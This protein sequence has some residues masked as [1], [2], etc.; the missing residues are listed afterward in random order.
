MARN[1]KNKIIIGL[2]SFF[3]IA[4]GSSIMAQGVPLATS[5]EL[6]GNLSSAVSDWINK[7]KVYLSGGQ[8]DAARE[9]FEEAI[10][11]NYKSSEA[12]F[13]LGLAEYERGDYPAALFE[14][15]EVARLYPEFFDGYYNRA[16]TL[17]KMRR[18]EEAAE[19]FQSAI[20]E[21]EPEAST[22]QKINAYLG[23]AGMLKK[24]ENYEAAADAYASALELREGDS[25]L[26]YRRGEAL[27]LAGNGLDALADLIELE[28]K[29]SDYRVSALI[30]DIYVQ[31]EQNDYAL[32]ALDRSLRKAQGA[33]DSK[34]ESFLSM[35]LG[36]LQS[37]LGQDTEAIASFQQAAAADPRSWKAR[38]YYGISYLS[39]GQPEAALGSLQQAQ[40]L[41][42]DS[43]EVNLAL[44]TAYDAVAMT[45][46][47]A[48]IA[49][50]IV[51]QFKDKEL[52]ASEAEALARAQFFIA[53]AKYMQGDYEAALEQFKE[54]LST[55]RD[56]AIVNMWA[57][58]CAYQL[59]KYET[60]INY[61]EQAVA[62]DPDNIDAKI[63]LGS[64]YYQA[65][66]YRDS[67]IVY[68]LL[69]EDNS[70]DAESYY[71]L[72]LSL[73]AQNLPKE[74]KDALTKASELGYAP[75]QEAL[76]QY[77]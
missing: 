77:F 40:A 35:K 1:L 74:A 11:L 9:S 58:L 43:P 31:N 49:S 67:A 10:A 53:K 59:E 63:N 33:A 34:A 29:T 22:V 23:L 32:H 46:E 62:S 44:A 72:G 48:Q 76:S 41:N 71:N 20:D 4:I 19:A 66:R 54:V 57:G 38:Y 7:G 36:L 13:G 8:F 69:V 12:H 75:A 16:I 37:S 56:D 2:V 26:A 14:F 15:G 28:A 55:N 5:Q 73:M 45:E 18:F 68:K 30:A 51:A 3:V 65:E 27:Y 52:S 17:A 25:E 39:L 47:S 24:T 50:L 6:S 42:P 60:A 61:L 64:A 70:N 21:A